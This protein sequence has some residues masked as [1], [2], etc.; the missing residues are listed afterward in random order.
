MGSTEAAEIGVIEN[1][2]GNEQLTTIVY[3]GTPLSS[4]AKCIG[5]FEDGV[6]ETIYWF[7]HDEGFTQS[8]TGKLDLIVSYDTKTGII[9]YHIESINDGFNINTTLN[10]DKKFLITGVNRVEN[11]LFFTDNINAPRRINVTKNYDDPVNNVDGFLAEDI[12]VIKRPPVDS[13]TIN[14][15]SNRWSRNFFRGKIYMFCI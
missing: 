9:Q 2:K 1:S 12:L 5:A 14:L 11:L 15:V 6:N 3:N 8:P 10:F 13:P 4:Q 7:I